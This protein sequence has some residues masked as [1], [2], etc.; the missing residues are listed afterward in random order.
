MRPHAL[1]GISRGCEV[2]RGCSTVIR[3]RHLSDTHGTVDNYVVIHRW[4]L[5]CGRAVGVY[6]VTFYLFHWKKGSPFA[7]DQGVYDKL[8]WWEQ[9]D[10]GRQLTR[11]RKFL[12][13]LPVLL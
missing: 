13:V 10:N 6:Q 7:E 9:V 11:G 2:C 8:T 12:T 4:L 1:G 3:S 5:R